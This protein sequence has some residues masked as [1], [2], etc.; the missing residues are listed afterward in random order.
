MHATLGGAM[1]ERQRDGCTTPESEAADEQDASKWNV[2]SKR[3]LSLIHRASA[4]AM[5]APRAEGTW[6]R[7]AGMDSP[8]MSAVSATTGGSVKAR[9][10]VKTRA[11]EAAMT[12]AAIVAG[13]APMSREPAW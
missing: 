6:P 4:T 10:L 11:G 2:R 1:Q 8:Q 3:P 13:H 7:V 5:P 12:A 9:R